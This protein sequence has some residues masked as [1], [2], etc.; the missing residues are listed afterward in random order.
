ME[1]SSLGEKR[2]RHCPKTRGHNHRVFRMSVPLRVASNFG[3]ILGQCL[4]LFASRNIGLAIII[5]S[6]TM[7]LP[8][9]VREKM[10][11]VILLISFM[12]IINVVGL[13]V[14]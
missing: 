9:F 5:F 7:S 11:D 8:F 6:S 3:L 10:W 4:L 14:R 1:T 13:F 2:A 12:Q